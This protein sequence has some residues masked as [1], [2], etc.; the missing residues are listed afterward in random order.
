MLA[1]QPFTVRSTYAVDPAAVLNIA[2]PKLDASLDAVFQ[3]DNSFRLRAA[4]FGDDLVNAELLPGFL[5]H[6]N[7]SKN[8]FTTKVELNNSLHK[9]FN[10]KDYLTGFVQF[11]NLS[12]SGVLDAQT[13][14]L[15]AHN[16][17]TFFSLTGD[18]TKFVSTFLPFPLTAE[19]SLGGDSVKASYKLASLTA[20]TNLKVHQDF[21]FTS[22]PHVHLVTSD[23]QVADFDAGGSATFT[24]PQG[25]PALTFTPTFSL[26]QPLFSNATSLII[27]PKIT[28]TPLELYAKAKA[29]STSLGSL[30]IKPYTHTFDLPD[31]RVRL[32]ATS[33]PVD[34]F[35]PFT[36][37]PITVTGFS[38]LSP[39]L[40]GVSPSS[41]GVYIAQV[42]NT[43]MADLANFK[44]FAAGTTTLTLSG[45]NI[46][47]GATAYFSYDGAQVPL[48]TL[49]PSPTTLTMQVLLPNKYLLLPGVG[50]FTVVNPAPDTAGP[51]NSLDFPIQYPIPQLRTVGPNL[52]AS[53]SDFR[54]VALTVENIPFSDGPY[55]GS[56]TMIQRK[57]YFQIL[58]DTLWPQ[59][60]GTGQ[61]LEAV[62]PN[63]DFSAP[64][65]LPTIFFNGQ[66]LPAYHEPTPSGLIWA[67]LP[68]AAYDR[69]QKVNVYA[70]SPGPGGGKS[71][72]VP[73]FVG[74]PT[75]KIT[76]LTPS[77]A[78]PGG[79]GFRLVVRGPS[80][81][82]L[83]DGT[84]T[85]TGSNGAGN[86]NAASVVYWGGSPR[87]TTF[88]SS[89]E[90]HADINAS[91]IATGSAPAVS[92]LNPGATEITPGVFGDQFAR[93][94]G[95]APLQPV[96][97][98]PR[99][100]PRLPGAVERGVTS[101]AVRVRPIAPGQPDPSGRGAAERR[102]HRAR[103]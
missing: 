15:A 12:T 81:L 66:P 47:P 11:P 53:D 4:A 2:S 9:D 54:N 49:T 72:V 38:N 65:P 21:A 73:H 99:V 23:S 32:Y 35:K 92:V 76:S 77:T 1:G 39:I 18:V 26:G 31:P 37:S 88:V 7:V 5:Q 50:R 70:L 102:Q 75:P 74:A 3:A 83:P 78:V 28:V 61:T 101:H 64:A 91:D 45:T 94:P 13:Q 60:F 17:D 19:V 69:P 16:D 27:V 97:Q 58:A 55:R 103:P 62:F 82:P 6:I 43:N 10:L 63:F 24:M 89:S 79:P 80:T 34:G 22:R 85:A 33:F 40:D 71:N 59:A 68:V 36:S 56:D 25:N 41:A 67:L 46:K 95:H 30:D 52:W 57:D 51:S 42:T 98:R 86:F 48:E 96:G 87:L 93:F 8:L 29:A 100:R 84:S 90:L 14:Q 44:N 20:T